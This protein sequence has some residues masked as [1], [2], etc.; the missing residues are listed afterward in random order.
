MEQKEIETIDG[1]DI[2]KRMLTDEEANR[3]I[4]LERF[5]EWHNEVGEDFCDQISNINEKILGGFLMCKHPDKSHQILKILNEKGDA[6]ELQ[7]IYEDDPHN[8]KFYTD[9]AE[10]INLTVH[11]KKRVNQ[12]LIQVM[13][14]YKS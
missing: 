4:T 13:E 5:Q 10:F 7:G 1:F 11:L 12:I 9:F 6:L 8:D 2:P 3:D 14:Y